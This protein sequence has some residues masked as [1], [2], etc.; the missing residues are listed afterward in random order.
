[1]RVASQAVALLRRS[2][3]RQSDNAAGRPFQPA[4][5]DQMQVYGGW[6][7]FQSDPRQGFRHRFDPF[8]EF[9]AGPINAGTFG[10]GEMDSAG[11]SFIVEARSRRRD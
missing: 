9:V 8:R 5:A 6:S 2:K 1:M 4:S 3:G 7:K 10:P 11:T